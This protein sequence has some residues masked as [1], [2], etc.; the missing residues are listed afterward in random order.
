MDFSLSEEQEMMRTMARDL[1]E[2]ECPEGLVRATIRRE[3]G[4]SPELWRQT[5][6]L[7]WAGIILPEEYGG[8]GGGVTDLAVL[9]E[10]IGRAMY[11]SP[12]L[13]TAVLCGNTILAAGSEELK[14][15]VLPRVAR[16]DIIMA[17]ALAEPESAW[18]GT[19]WEP[20]GV[21]VTAA[22]DGDDYVIDGV[23]LFV[24]DAHVADR[25]LC[26]ARTRNGG[27]PDDGITLFLVD[28]SSPGISCTQLKTMSGSHK[29]SEV[30]FDKVK[31]PAKSIVGELHGG[32][33]PLAESMKIGAVMLCAEMTG[34]GQK[35]L[36]MTVDYAKTRLQFDMPI[37]INQHV[38]AHCVQLVADVDTSRWLTYLAAWKLGEGLPSDFDVSVAKA[39]TSDAVHQVG[40]C[41]PALSG[42]R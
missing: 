35:I 31:V 29:Q 15:D 7:G 21:K 37:G 39:W 23:K 22:A 6:D 18:N 40:Q 16:G 10:E 28:A 5:A 34:A 42:R 17:L 30:I 3:E 20:G 33:A 1:L 11:I 25:I 24:H 13:S 27:A 41:R 32:W 26:V 8:I 14:K 38:Q 2:K 19:A 12:L 36:E 4:Y 9:F